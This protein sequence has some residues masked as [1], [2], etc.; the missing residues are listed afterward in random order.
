MPFKHMSCDT[1]ANYLKENPDS[2]AIVD[3]RDPVSFSQ[4]HIDGARHIDN[5]TA[6][7]YLASADFDKPLIV[8]CYHGNSSQ[9]AAEYF[10]EQ[11]FKDTYSLDGGFEEWKSKALS[12]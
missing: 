6:A 8:C 10:S 4:G 11:G 1:L 3:I 9:G 5:N 2:V 12:K 7:D